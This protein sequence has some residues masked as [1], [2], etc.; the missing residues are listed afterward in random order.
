VGTE[1]LPGDIIAP[2]SD[3][4]PRR[5]WGKPEEVNVGSHVGSDALNRRKSG[6]GL[7]SMVSENLL[8]YESMTFPT[9]AFQYSQ[10]FGNSGK[11]YSSSSGS[12]FF[13]F[14]GLWT[15]FKD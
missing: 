4:Y 9:A 7:G 11:T 12:C 1:S 3:L 10:E 8:T 13:C 5:L 6:Q 15:G 14:S 2:L